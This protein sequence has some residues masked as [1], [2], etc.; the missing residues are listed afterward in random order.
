MTK[1]LITKYV[2]LNKIR[3]RKEVILIAKSRFNK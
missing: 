3:T 2:S 1:N